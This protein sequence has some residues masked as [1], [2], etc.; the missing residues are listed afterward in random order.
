MLGRSRA[1][2]PSDIHNGE[3]K[4]II[5]AE[6]DPNQSVCIHRFDCAAFSTV[7]LW[8]CLFFNNVYSTQRSLFLSVTYHL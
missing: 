6:T 4:K 7:D 3:E 2:E 5:Q 8:V 1:L